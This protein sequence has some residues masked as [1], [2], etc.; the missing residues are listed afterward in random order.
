MAGVRMGFVTSFIKQTILT[1]VLAAVALVV[2]LRTDETAQ[3]RIGQFGLDAARLEQVGLP[4]DLLAR[5]AVW[6]EQPVPAQQADARPQGQGGAGQGSAGG[7]QAGRPQQGQAPSA[8]GVQRP[9][10]QG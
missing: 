5:I 2:W 1:L 4:P 6:P 10:G 8:G 3:A 7:A 9:G